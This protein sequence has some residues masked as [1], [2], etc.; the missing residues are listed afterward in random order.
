MCHF[1]IYHTKQ[2]ERISNSE[3]A[4]RRQDWYCRYA[5]SDTHLPVDRCSYWA[6]II[7]ANAYIIHV[8]VIAD[9]GVQ[10]KKGM[11]NVKQRTFCGVGI[12]HDGRSAGVWINGKKSSRDLL[13]SCAGDTLLFRL[14]PLQRRLT[15]MNS[16]TRQ[17]T[18]ITDV[19][20]D[21]PLF[22]TINMGSAAA[23]GPLTQMELRQVTDAERDMLQ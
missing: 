5:V 16:R 17:E 23:Y 13:A 15:V 6:A 19:V 8:G 14:D 21:T 22:I 9:K 18:D 3:L 1:S 20:S 4:T 10:H 11:C 12:Y 7:K 2:L